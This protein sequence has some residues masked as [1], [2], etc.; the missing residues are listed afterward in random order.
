MSQPAALNAVL[1]ALWRY[2]ESKRVPPNIPLRRRIDPCE[3]PSL[4]PHVQ[5]VE[6]IEDRGFRYRLT[7]TEV[8]QGYGRDPTGKFVDDVLP[9]ERRAAANRHYSMALYLR[10][11]LY[12]LG[13]Y[14]KDGD[15]PMVSRRI[16]LPLSLDGKSGGMLLV[17]ETFSFPEP[18]ESP[19]D[20][21]FRIG[22]DMV[23][24]LESPPDCRAA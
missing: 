17:G 14:V 3:I 22:S 8:V 2:W 1:S 6:H 18:F 21:P 15:L 4:L 13:R 16:I 5:L 10:Q 19:L 7:G 9:P 23:E 12:A 11:P 24:V 20:D